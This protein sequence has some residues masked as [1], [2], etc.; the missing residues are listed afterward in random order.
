MARLAVA[1]VHHAS[2]DL[3]LRERFSALV[4]AARP[5]PDFLP[6]LTCHR[7]EVYAV[8]DE[9]AEPRSCFEARLGPLPVPVQ[10]AADEEAVRHLFRVASGLDSAIPGERQ[11]L[12][13]LRAAYDRTRPDGTRSELAGLFERALHVGR[14]L[15]ATT[16]LGRVTASLGSLAV[17]A[18]LAKVADPERATVV[19]V[20]A[21]EMGKLASRAL[22]RRVAELVIV[23]RDV[24]RALP[25]ADAAGGAAFP[26]EA[27]PDILR[28]ADALISAADT[29]GTVLTLE[30]LQEPAARGLVVVDI[31]MPRSVA[32]AAR[33][34]LG[35]RYLTVDD[36]IPEEQIIGDAER[37]ALEDRCAQEAASFLVALRGRG[38]GETIARLRERAEA[39]RQQRLGKALRDL[40]HL[41][42][43]DRRVIET[44][45][46][47]L[48]SA[49]IHEPITSL[50]ESPERVPA[51]RELFR[52]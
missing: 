16:S 29:R 35:D 21:G 39:L 25:L 8:I 17:A 13:Q 23:N 49:L 18:A 46:Q 7:A 28:R 12:G 30:L 42:E 52:L 2:A 34:A 22:G 40:G 27:L 38:A 24:A 48:T 51:A 10:I 43:R 26:L 15:R 31:A 3:E 47:A 41:S 19:V 36:L 37:D 45:S 33:A 4:A 1:R 44:F 9:A 50:R 14:Q 20:G 5:A 32:A 6:L 11:I